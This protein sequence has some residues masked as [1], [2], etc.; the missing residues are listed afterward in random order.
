MYAFNYAK[1]YEWMFLYF[2]LPDFVIVP[3]EF[4]PNP[5]LFCS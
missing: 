1:L 2:I 4:L 5:L 3:S